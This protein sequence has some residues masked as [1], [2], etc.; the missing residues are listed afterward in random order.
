MNITLTPERERNMRREHARLHPDGLLP[1]GR[2]CD[3]CLV[4]TQLDVEREKVPRRC[5][6]QKEMCATYGCAHDRVG[7][8]V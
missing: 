2:V 5:C 1:G 8:P 6:P 3:V 4:L 7:V